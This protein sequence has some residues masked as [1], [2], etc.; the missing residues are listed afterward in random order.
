MKGWSIE[1]ETR[2]LAQ[3]FSQSDFD[4]NKP[5]LTD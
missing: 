2:V 1:G 4:D 3:G 5:W